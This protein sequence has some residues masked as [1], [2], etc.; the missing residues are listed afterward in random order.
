MQTKTTSLLSRYF[1]P[2]EISK[3]EGHV[4]FSDSTE[5]EINIHDIKFEVSGDDLLLKEFP[6][7]YGLQMDH[8]RADDFNTWE[9]IAFIKVR[10]INSGTDIINRARTGDLYDESYYTLR[11]GG[12]PYV[13]Y[14]LNVY[15]Y[16]EETR[17]IDL[18]KE[19][20]DKYGKST[21]LDCGCATGVL[22]N[23]F[24][25]QGF[26]GYGFDISEYA[27]KNGIC[28]N[29][30]H[31]DARNLPFRNDQFDILI[32]QDFME[33]VHPDDLGLVLTEQKRIL[34]PGG[35]A[36]HFIPFYK[37]YDKPVQIDAHLCNANRAWWVEYFKSS[38][39]LNV[40][41]IPDE[42]NQWDYSNG[43]LVKYF[44]LRK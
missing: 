4:S 29:L 13:N 42:D 2:E 24:Q 10:I 20:A 38:G 41:Y 28:K 8:N 39:I 33:H 7:K 26:D 15:G 31:A 32:S 21:I 12:S 35:V 14:P 23:Q 5:N 27:I 9:S 22:V 43:I 34:K 18:A 36:L 44:V 37:E 6:E 1:T 16:S 19:I 17:F 25:L 11:G 3:L 40:D 30:F